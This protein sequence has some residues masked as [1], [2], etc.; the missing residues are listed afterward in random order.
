[1]SVDSIKL[2]CYPM[3]CACCVQQAVQDDIDFPQSRVCSFR[4]TDNG[5][6]HYIVQLTRIP[7]HEPTYVGS[8]NPRRQLSRCQSPNFLLRAYCLSSKIGKL[9]SEIL[10]CTLF[11]VLYTYLVTISV[12]YCY[13][14][15][16]FALCDFM[17]PFCF[18]CCPS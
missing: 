5:N 11:Y 18:L 6:T 13:N 2:C 14:F 12:C 1:M 7:N 10:W 8:Y 9:F 15:N 17:K 4:Y 16:E 3:L